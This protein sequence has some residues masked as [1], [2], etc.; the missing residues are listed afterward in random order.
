M[1]DT[2]RKLEYDEVMSISVVCYGDSNTFGTNPHGGRWGTDVR[3][4]RVLGRLLGSG[5]DVIEE[6]LGGRETV[7]DD[8]LVGERNGLKGLPYVLK[9]HKPIDI[10]VISLGT[11]DTKTMFHATPK[12]IALGIEQLILMAQRFPY[13]DS[14]FY[15]IPRIV[16]V[17]PIHVGSHIDKCPYW[18]FDESSVKTSHEVA[19]YIEEIARKHGCSFLDAAKVASPSETDQLHME[20]EGH[21]A[22]AKALET[23]VRSIHVPSL[24]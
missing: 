22:L 2:S 17:S 9:T 16:V 20:K 24:S 14:R 8:P 11:N 3:W 18:E 23:L 1:L 12:V 15:P 21:L 13:G 7:Y 4:P 10:L 6:G 5:Y 19:P